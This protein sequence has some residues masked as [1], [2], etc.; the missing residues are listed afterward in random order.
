MKQSVAVFFLIISAVCVLPAQVSITPG[1]K[2]YSQSFDGLSWNGTAGTLVAWSENSTIPGWHAYHGRQSLSYTPGPPAKYFIDDGTATVGGEGLRSYGSL[3]AGQMNPPSDRALGEYSS[4]A[5]SIPYAFALRFVNTS[6]VP[7]N[8]FSV[9]Y[10]GEQW[11]Q[12]TGTSGLVFEYQV[13]A[14]SIMTGTWTPVTSLD[15]VPLKNGAAGPLDGNA[16]GNR[17]PV[18]GT[19]DAAVQ[20]GQEIWMRWTKKGT[21]SCG[22]AVDDLTAAFEPTAQPANLSFTDVTATS[23]RISFASP[24]PSSSGCLMLR[25]AGSP[26]TG[27]P[28]DGTGYST[29]DSVGDAR[30]VLAGTATTVSQSGLDPDTKYYYAVFAFNGAGRYC[31]YLTQNPLTGS[32]STRVSLASLNS[33][34]TGVPGSES[35][36][37]PSTVND[38]SPLSFGQGAQVWQ[39]TVRDGGGAGDSDAKPTV[40]T[41]LSLTQGTQNTVPDWSA[42]IRAAG[43][44]SGSTLL[45]DGMIDARSIT[46]T[47]LNEL[48]PDNGARTY[49]LRISLKT[50]DL[51]DHQVF[52]CSAVPENVRTESDSTSS[53]MSSF[54]PAISDG[55]KNTIQVT[56]SKLVFLQQPVST[57]V[58]HPIHPAVTVAAVDSNDN[59]DIDYVTPVLATANGAVLSGSPVSAIP[60]SGIAAFTALVFNTGSPAVTLNVSSNGWQSTSASFRVETHRTFYVDSISGNDAADG[61]SSGTAWKTLSKV[62]NTV[63]QP[64][65]SLLFRSG[66]TWSGMLSPKGSGDSTAP[67]V[68]DSYGGTVR[69]V[70]NGNG[71]TGYGTLY[72]Y[73]Q[74][75]WEVNNLEIT[76]NAAAGGDRRGV[77]IVF[78]NA[79]VVRHFYLRGLYIHNVKG[80]V[81]DDAVHK[82]TAG[83]GIETDDNGTVPTRGDDFLIEN[84]TIA[85]V[86]NQGIFTANLASND[87]PMSSGWLSRRFT[88]FRI[89][90]NTIHHI[91]KNAMIIRF[92]D[93]GVIEH[94]VCYETATGTTGNTMFTTYCNGTVFQYNE[95]YY[96]RASLKGG[97]FGDGSMY[98]A[99]LKSVNITFQYSYSHDNSHGLLWICTDQADSNIV[100]RYNVSKNDQG[101]IFCINYPNTSVYIYN[102][103]V[104]CETG[105]PMIVSERNVNGPNPAGPRTYYFYNNIIYSMSPNTRPY[106]FRATLYNRYFDYNLYYGYSLNEPSDPHKIKANPQ[107][108]NVPSGTPTGLNSVAGLALKSTSPAVNAGRDVYGRPAID[109]LGKTVPSDGSV[110]LGAFEYQKENSIADRNNLLPDDP[111]LDQNYPNPFNPSTSISYSVPSEQHVVLEVYNLLGMKVRALVNGT[112]PAGSY[113]IA[114]DAGQLPAG[115]Y[116]YRL[117]AGGR[118]YV[119]RMALVK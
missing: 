97:D 24:V 29:G 105:S 72:F 100:C 46:F 106:D 38:P 113:R 13:G 43:L 73:N 49:S 76:N 59:T 83:I 6:G 71:L 44:F 28:Q 15:F 66:C 23:M 95:G 61:L 111:V 19:I 92:F 33:D 32:Q 89:R 36:D 115:M 42:G 58:G 48:I 103:T 75:Y 54:V 70:I 82:R 96:N 79:G 4:T 35:T 22:L 3:S 74:Q 2:Y 45:A 99:D 85:Y 116:L 55:S 9:S 56:A 101:I 1:M 18:S 25:K 27:I 53:Q 50:Q 47:G 16:P 57:T 98:D 63:F 51:T 34:I 41:D 26:P 84:C 65:D 31:N 118:E 87:Y 93:G 109:Y 108:F 10:T 17:I 67:I 104:Y 5:D 60:A 77:Y 68:I 78:F 114:F 30:V 88:N 94:N 81:G 110:D 40:I 117:T 119:R 12:N 64:G 91:S 37:V 107:F 39:F 90:K 20:N 112:V 69:P 86:E 7:L 11:K 62:N 52:Q 21:Q 80:L 8:S 102:N 14:S